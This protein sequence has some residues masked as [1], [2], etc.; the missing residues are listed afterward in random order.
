MIKEIVLKSVSKRILKSLQVETG[1]FLAS[2]KKV[3][4]GYN[5]AWIRDNIYESLGF[6]AVK[7][8][9]SLKKAYY[10]LFDILLKH[11]YKIDWAIKQKPDAAYKYIHAR[12]NPLTFDEYCDFWGN[13][14]ND[15]VGAFLF[16][17]GEL[18]KK[19]IV[20][21]RDFKD[22]RMLQKL[23]HYLAS[24]EYWHDS[25][26]GMWENDEEVHASSVGACVSGLKAIKGIVNV[27]DELMAEGQDALNKLLPRE[28]KSRE[29]DL[30]LLS[31]I[32][33]FK[34]VS[35]QQRAQILKNVEEKLVR[36]KGVIRYFNDWYYKNGH[37]A[38]WT[39]GFAWLAKI[40]KDLGNRT[41]YNLYM[42]K[43]YKSMNW[44]GELPELY[45]YNTDINKFVNNENTP[46]GWSQAMYLVAVS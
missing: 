26:S 2:K 34:V 4:T 31:L 8:I 12:Y 35:V 41:K 32:Y 29:V 1:L 13:K 14:Q 43:L 28:S 17:V 40:Y 16:K 25:D 46:L 18:F 7:D 24:I 30:A 20:V 44:K 3:K 27:P 11:E 23:V 22:I 38:Q 10:A 36:E 6:E 5:R 33:P 45:Y 9:K 21:F 19:K 42:E 39:F 37:E 15:S